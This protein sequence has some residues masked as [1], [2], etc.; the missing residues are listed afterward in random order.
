MANVY[1][2]NVPS[3]PYLQYGQGI[4]E[5]F[6]SIICKLHVYGTYTFIQS[7][8][9]LYPLTAWSSKYRYCDSVKYQIHI[10]NYSNVYDN[11]TNNA[12]LTNNIKLTRL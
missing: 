12:F 5:A 6:F 11:I 8:S 2:I 1:L 7:Q 10:P 4:S 3:K 9:L